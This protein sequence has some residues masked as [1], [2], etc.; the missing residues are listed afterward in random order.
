[1]KK[2]YLVIKFTQVEVQMV[3][4]ALS[5]KFKILPIPNILAHGKMYEHGFVRKRN[6]HKLCTNSRKSR[7]DQFFMHYLE[8]LLIPNVLAHGKLYK[9]DFMKKYDGHKIYT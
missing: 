8:M 1:M 4:Y 6:G 9:H 7:F 2:K 5:R 3:F